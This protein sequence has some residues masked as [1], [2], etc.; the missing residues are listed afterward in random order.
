MSTENSTPAE[1]RAEPTPEDR[2]AARRLLDEMGSL[3]Y[4]ERQH[5]PDT[6]ERFAC[7]F[8]AH[9]ARREVA[10][11]RGFRLP[12][13]TTGDGTQ[14]GGLSIFARGWN[15][16]LQTI[17]KLNPGIDPIGGCIDVSH[18]FH[19]DLSLSDRL[20]K[21]LRASESEVAGLRAALERIRE[22]LVETY[23]KLDSL[24]GSAYGE[25]GPSEHV[26][27]ILHSAKTALRLTAVLQSGKVHAD[28]D[29]LRALLQWFSVEDCQCDATAFLQKKIEARNLL[30]LRPAHTQTKSTP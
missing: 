27:N 19:L 5:A 24:A 2:V 30:A 25:K 22:S 9:C 16:C 7:H 8:A 14:A 23:T 29:A 13:Q 15:G 17:R 6:A 12:A 4:A 18:E 28:N 1:P 21:A 20:E 10:L 11:R 26:M 3:S